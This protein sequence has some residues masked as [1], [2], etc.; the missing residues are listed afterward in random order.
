VSHLLFADD[1]LLFFRANVEQAQ[2]V[3][4]TFESCSGQLLSPSKCSMLGNEKL[5][6]ST[7]EQ[8]RIVL[9]VERVAQI[10]KTVISTFESCS[11]AAIKPKQMLH[12]G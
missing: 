11:G 12:A 8:V 6:Q 4:S 9:G 7:S 10:I 1:S 2:I 5:D 3:I